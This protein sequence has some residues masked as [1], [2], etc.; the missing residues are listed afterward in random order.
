[1]NPSERT[2]M[3]AR[4]RIL[5]LLSDAETASVSTAETAI[6]LADGEEYLDLAHLD[7]GVQ[8]A[9]GPAPVM[10]R[11]V[12]RKAVHE[13]TWSR[14]QAELETLRQSDGAPGKPAPIAIREK[15]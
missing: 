1:M 9:H 5:M 2:E 10:G 13:E 8:R 3:L 6:D 7:Q 15:L 11:V 4:D 12:P 14:I